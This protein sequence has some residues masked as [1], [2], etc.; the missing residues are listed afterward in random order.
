MINKELCKWGANKV[1]HRRQPRPPPAQATH[2]IK[3]MG[4]LD[5]QRDYHHHH[6]RCHNP[7]EVWMYAWVFACSIFC[8]LCIFCVFCIFCIFCILYIICILCI[9]GIFCIFCIF[10]ILIRC[11]CMLGSLPAT[12]PRLN[13]RQSGPTTPLA[14]SSGIHIQT[15]T[16]KVGLRY[17]AS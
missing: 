2:V 15:W 3:K 16:M 4:V 7:H 14:P 9:L 10:I 12:W 13:T 11:G 5:H 17:H 8:K 1:C 6:H